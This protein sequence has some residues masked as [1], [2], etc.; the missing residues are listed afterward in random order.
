MMTYYLSLLPGQ[1]KTYS[2]PDSSFW[3]C[4]GTGMENHAKYGDTI[5]FHDAGASLSEPFHPRG[6]DVEG[7]G[8]DGAS[9]DGFSL[10]K[11]DP[12]GVPL[13]QARE[14]GRRRALS[15]LGLCAVDAAGRR[16]TG[17]GGFTPGRYALVDRT[18]KDGDTLDVAIPM[19]LHVEAMPDN[20]NRIALLYGPILL[21]GALG[22][23][24]WMPDMIYRGLTGPQGPTAKAP[25]LATGGRPP[26]DWIKQ[27]SQKPLR[28]PT[29][30]RWA[31]E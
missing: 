21:A 19:N 4:V 7:K 22:S 1:F 24:P 8:A 29:R 20:P 28:I 15:G 30:R 14:T 9:G 6:V 25:A 2:T 18:W 27:V 10:D 13:R 11:F 5:F 26:E 23:E 17:R 16:R 31:A 3:C 12:A